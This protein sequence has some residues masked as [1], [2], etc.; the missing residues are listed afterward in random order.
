MESSL[1]KFTIKFD[2]KEASNLEQKIRRYYR[3]VQEGNETE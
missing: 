1:D 3:R 2:M